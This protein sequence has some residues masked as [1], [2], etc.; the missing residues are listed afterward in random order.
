MS[1]ESSTEAPETS[2]DGARP[3]PGRG[4]ETHRY[5]SPKMTLVFARGL[6]GAAVPPADDVPPPEPAPEP[7]RQ[8][9][10][11]LRFTEIPL[12]KR[13]AASPANQPAPKRTMIFGSNADPV[14]QVEAKPEG[15]RPRM[16]SFVYGVKREEPTDA[17]PS[18]AS[19][20]VE[21]APR[22][23][24]DTAELRDLPKHTMQLPEPWLQPKLFRLP[25]EAAPARR[26]RWGARVGKLF[27]MFAVAAGT[28]YSL[29]HFQVL[30]RVLG[31]R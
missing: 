7:P 14:P 2:P 4:E 30:E 25:T 1:K 20:A 15:S 5:E 17:R 16:Q 26:G 9:E 12:G 13:L 6:G 3:F 10:M 18:T 29:L 19:G 27:V 24:G 23:R 11:T 22:G 8:S 28:A 31:P 21:V